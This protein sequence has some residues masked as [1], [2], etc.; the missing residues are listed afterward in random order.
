MSPIDAVVI[1]GGQYGLAASWQLT[2]R[3]IEHV[4]LERGEVAQTWRSERW[5]SFALNTPTWMNRMPGDPD[6]VEPRDAFLTRAG[7]VERFET[8]AER[9]RL[10]VRTSTTVTAVEPGRRAGTFLVSAA[11][12]D[13]DG[14]EVIEA[15]DVVVASGAQPRPRRPTLA[16]QLPS[17]VHQLHSVAYRSPG[18]LPG[19]AVLVIGSAQSGVQIAEDLVAAD[20][21][22]YL[23]TSP[24][25][26]LR[27][28]QRGRDSLDWLVRVGF[29]DQTPEQLPD[30]DM[31]AMP[32]PQISGVGPLGH[33][34]GLQSLQSLGVRLLGRPIAVVGDRIQLDDSLGENIA[35]G[36][37][38]SAQLNAIV[39]QGIR[40][41]GETPLPLEPDP[42]DDPHPDATSVHSPDHV[43]LEAQDISTVIWA[44]GYVAD[45]G[46]LRVPVLDERGV[47]V[48]DR[49]AAQMPGIHF[50][51]LRWL[52]KRK[53]AL[54][55]AADEE[56]AALAARIAGPPGG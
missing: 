25:G 2:H 7:V 50:L 21:T 48:H 10:P 30:P 35:V 47:P 46:F 42:A 28:R 27:R 53:S 12:R 31:M 13:G 56:S 20:R 14:S 24:V 1:G 6:D 26:R 4:V 36:D 55:N 39:E 23:C 34:V 51:G 29:Y 3:G 19:G 11:G 41:L 38:V 17:T 33:T 54:L 22:V 8:Y 52:T 32:I 44:T 37:R 18:A 45:F 15:R 16:D 40:E 5:D 43:D 49:G 9:H